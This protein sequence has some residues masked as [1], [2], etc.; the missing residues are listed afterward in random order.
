MF[1]N[2]CIIENDLSMNL[3]LSEDILMTYL[4]L[5]LSEVDFFCGATDAAA[6]VAAVTIPVLG[7]GL[8][9]SGTVLVSSLHCMGCPSSSL[10]WYVVMACSACSRLV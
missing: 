8:V 10:S 4:N 9:V 6:T 3:S 2:F 7:L 1:H 5:S